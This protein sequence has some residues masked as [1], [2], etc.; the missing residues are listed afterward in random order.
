MSVYNSLGVLQAQK[1]ES[2]VAGTDE[3]MYF[4]IRSFSKGMY[5]VVLTNSKG[6]ILASKAIA[7]Q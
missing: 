4:D 7:I 5:H 1:D 2:F 6:Q 3:V